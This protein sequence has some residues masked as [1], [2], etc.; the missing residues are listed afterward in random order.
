MKKLGYLVIGFIFICMLGIPNIA[1]AKVDEK[2]ELSIC[3]NNDDS[4]LTD[5]ILT[6]LFER[7]G[8]KTNFSTKEMSSALH[9]VNEGQFDVLSGQTADFEDIY[10]NL[11][12]VPEKTGEI[13]FNVYGKS[14][15]D[16]NIKSWSDLEGL[17][18]GYEYQRPHVTN[19]LEKVGVTKTVCYNTKIELLDAVSRGIVD[20]AI[21]PQKD[22]KKIYIPPNIKNIGVAEQS[23]LFLFVNKKWENLVPKIASTYRQMKEKGVIEQ[24]TQGDSVKNDEKKLILHIMSYN[25]ENQSEESLNVSIRKAIMEDQNAQLY[26]IGLNSN[27][28]ENH[29]VRV[30]MFG[31]MLRTDFGTRQPDVIIISNSYAL[32]FLKEYYYKMFDGIPI[33]YLGVDGED[34]TGFEDHILFIEKKI[35]VKETVEQALKLFPNT[36]NIFV[37]NDTLKDGVAWTRII[38]KELKDYKG[39]LN[40]TYSDQMSFDELLSEITNLS[41]DTIIFSG[42]YYAGISER[43]YTGQEIQKLFEKAYNRPVFS[44]NITGLLEG[45]LGGKYIDTNIIGE[46]IGELALELAD[47]KSPDSIEVDQSRISNQWIYDYEQMQKWNITENQVQNQVTIYNK[48]VTF[49]DSNPTAFRLLVL[50]IATFIVAIAVLVVMI[51]QAQRKNKELQKTQKSLVRAEEVIEKDKQIRKVKEK[52]ETIIGT[53]PLAYIVTSESGVIKETNNYSKEVLG[54]AIGNEL[55][56]FISGEKK[57]GKVLSILSENGTLSGKVV[58]IKQSTNQIWR[59]HLNATAFYDGKE[60]QYII[61]ATNI[62]ELEKQ[63]DEIKR[64]QR[65]LNMIINSLPRPICIIN[66]VDTFI[67]YANDVF[68]NYFGGEDGSSPQNFWEIFPENQPNGESSE[69][70]MGRLFESVVNSDEILTDEFENKLPGGEIITM[71]GS[72]TEIVYN[73]EKA[74]SLILQDISAEKKQEEILKNTAQK[75]KEANQLKSKFIIN[76]SHEIRTPM[77]AIIGLTK[78][79]LLKQHSSDAAE[80]FQ[81]INNAAN[82]LLAIIN[83]I[84]DFSN[85]EAHK[86]EVREEKFDLEKIISKILIS[87]AQKLIDKKVEMLLQVDASIPRYIYGDKNI[88]WQILK[89]VLDN[90]AKFTDYGNIILNIRLHETDDQ[91]NMFLFIIEDSGR[92]IEADNIDKIFIPFEQFGDHYLKTSGTGLGMPITKRLAE[93]MGGFV[94]IESTVDVG[95]KVSIGLPLKIEDESKKI[96]EKS[97]QSVLEGKN[98]LIVDDCD[99]ACSIMEDLLNHVGVKTTTIVKAEQVI[100]HVTEVYE[101]GEYYDI[102][103]LDYLLDKGTGIEIG[104]RIKEIFTHNVKILMVSAYSRFHL[105]ELDKENVFNDIIDKP[106]IP[107]EFYTKICNV[108]EG[109]EHESDNLMDLYHFP[110]ARVLVC[111]DN[112]I[113]QEV[114]RGILEFYSIDPVIVNDGKE[115]IDCLKTREFDLVIMDILMPVMD[116]H[117]AT[118]AIRNSDEDFKDIP[119]VAMTANAM[120]EEKEECFKEG[121]N[122]YITKPVDLKKLYQE[123]LNWLPSEQKQQE[124]SNESAGVVESSDK[125]QADDVEIMLSNMGID[126][127]TGVERFGGKKELYKKTLKS[128]VRETLKDGMMTF[129]PLSD[130][131][132]MDEFK[133]YIHSMKGVTGNLSMNNIHNML[134]KFENS[135]KSGKPDPQ[136][137]HQLET[138]FLEKCEEI[139]ELL[140]DKGDTEL[141]VGSAS[142]C[143]DLLNELKTY[144]GQGKAR[145]CERIIT[146]L[147]KKKWESF[148][149]ETIEVICK[150]VDEYDYQTA[151]DYIN[152]QNI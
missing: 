69:R 55:D 98:A 8:Y 138:I 143:R 137:Y 42:T 149:G 82:I 90:A 67:V 104:K 14:D 109:T 140:D 53:A 148:D 25:M 125:A 26:T 10:E 102:I 9:A 71:R 54:F 66:P 87:S 146:K 86:V 62:E 136:L 64:T 63:K 33:I 111:E 73:R 101:R 108:V 130:E 39:R 22:S 133:R 118:V 27:M 93:L 38:K 7:V 81:K 84:L 20:V 107:S 36:K 134:K 3:L 15:S 59:Y 24:I 135:M 70:Y 74:I 79:E 17:K 94:A 97:Y 44:C 4:I 28:R 60:N 152:L 114:I 147:R 35:E 141:E 77:N 139:L 124:D 47:G 92:G 16:W 76:M 31:D 6:E 96:V 30:K 122:G 144:L 56:D 105:D 127:K 132:D 41:D 32:E 40:I 151:I 95:T 58:K 126:V 51:K 1:L 123:L 131:K 121:M 112:L 99:I 117:T 11:V 113:N 43:Y 12:R 75:E 65:D 106:F 18:V 50:L 5:R 83:D 142:E 23:D 13:T 45:E 89:N 57:K 72:A 37:I 88:V 103:L 80:S 49:W 61:W 48:K 115:G 2:R 110:N 46:Y 68:K 116:G 120:N 19:Q 100:P 52:L 34:I 150:A 78:I 145:E 21:I 129:D 29:D 128:F 85:I 119:I 91:Q